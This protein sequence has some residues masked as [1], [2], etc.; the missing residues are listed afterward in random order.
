MLKDFK[1]SREGIAGVIC[2][3]LWVNFFV[4]MVK[5]PFGYMC[6]GCPWGKKAG[7]LRSLC[8]SLL[9]RSVNLIKWFTLTSRRHESEAIN[10]ESQ[11]YEI[12]ILVVGR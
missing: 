1:N 3:H 7:A 8:S 2:V 9:I 4:I 6:E 5:S 12:I 11:L 10:L